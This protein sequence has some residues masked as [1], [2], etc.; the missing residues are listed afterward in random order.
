MR[1]MFALLS[2]NFSY[3]VSKQGVD[4]PLVFFAVLDVLKFFIVINY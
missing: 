3:E 4:V 2:G 1:L